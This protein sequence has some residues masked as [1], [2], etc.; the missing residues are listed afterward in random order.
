MD[1]AI[2]PSPVHSSLVDPPKPTQK[3]ILD[4]MQR[5]AEA[6]YS[7]VG[8]AMICTLSRPDGRYHTAGTVP[9]L[10]GGQTARNAAGER[11]PIAPETETIEMVSEAYISL[12]NE[13]QKWE[14]SRLRQA[15]LDYEPEDDRVFALWFVAA[16][17]KEIDRYRKSNRGR[18]RVLRADDL[19]GADGPRK[20]RDEEGSAV[21]E[22]AIDWL[23]TLDTTDPKY[24]VETEEIIFGGH[25]L[26]MDWIDRLKAAR[27]SFGLT[28]RHLSVIL[29]VASNMTDGEISEMLSISLKRVG[30]LKSECKS[31]MRTARQHA[32]KE[33]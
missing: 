15:F 2:Q 3:E 19:G 21:F 10:L 4:W 1:K 12:L 7:R 13:L 16:Q 23:S 25:D 26:A 18:L 8:D 28:D 22:N 17:R 6:H 20:N 30:N 33:A 27:K 5:A 24:G 11:R 14:P 31:I 9:V 29:A 32:E